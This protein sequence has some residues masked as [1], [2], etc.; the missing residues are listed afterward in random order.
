MLRTLDTM[1]PST[2][3]S[4]KFPYLPFDLQT[5]GPVSNVN[6]F[7]FI[8]GSAGNSSSRVN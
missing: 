6:Q 1:P 3:K 8:K 2:S 4:E 5:E 7:E